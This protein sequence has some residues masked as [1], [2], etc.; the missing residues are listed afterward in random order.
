MLCIITMPSITMLCI[1]SHAV[2][3]HIPCH[4]SPP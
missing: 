2:H 1:A 3:H 4:A